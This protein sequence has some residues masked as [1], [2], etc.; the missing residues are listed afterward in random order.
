[1]LPVFM[2]FFLFFRYEDF[3]GPGPKITHLESNATQT[4][5]LTPTHPRLK[6]TVTSKDTKELLGGV[7]VTLKERGGSTS[8]GS[9]KTDSKGVARF[10]GLNSSLVYEVTFNKEG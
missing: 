1:M 10:L 4:I 8:L 2:T 9:E 5:A 3:S 6:V 7:D